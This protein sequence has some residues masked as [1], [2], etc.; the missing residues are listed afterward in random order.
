MEK[1]D[2]TMEARLLLAFVLMGLVLF[3]TQYF[4]KPPPVATKPAVAKTDPL[5]TGDPLKT[6]DVSKAADAPKPIPTKPASDVAT[7]QM[8]A[9][10]EETLAVDTDFYHVV[11]SNRGAVVRNWILKAYKD[12]K[13][14]PLD[15]VNSAATGKVPPALSI[16]FKGQTPASDPNAGLFRAEHSPDN[17]RL[18]FEFA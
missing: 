1:K 6:A 11:F 3:G 17:L 16:A 10:K 13:G 12:H 14:Q 8:Q 2:M 9:E 15:L 18:T 7:A 5:K 4:Y